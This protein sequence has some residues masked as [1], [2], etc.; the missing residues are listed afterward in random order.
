M[1]LWGCQ[2]HVTLVQTSLFSYLCTIINAIFITQAQT[3]TQTLKPNYIKQ[4][5]Q[6]DTHIILT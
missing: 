3:I 5:T 2:H 4:S 6:K 1:F